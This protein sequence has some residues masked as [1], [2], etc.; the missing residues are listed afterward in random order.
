MMLSKHANSKSIMQESVTILQLELTHE[1]LDQGRFTSTVRSDESNSGFQV[2]VNVNTSQDRV[3]R[4][5]PYICFIKTAKRRRDLLWIR[6]H[7][8]ASWILDNFSDDINSLDSLDSRLYKR[9]SLCVVSELIDE[10]L[11]MIDLVHLFITSSLFILVFLSL[12]LSELLE[13]TPVVC[14][15]LRLEMNNFIDGGVKEVTCMRYYDN[16]CLVEF[17]DVVLEPD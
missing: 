17:L 7:E 10:L 16:S 11:D 5:I 4:S 2:D 1:S 14:Q 9:G 13:V 8:D 3:V 15:L 6:E 12:G